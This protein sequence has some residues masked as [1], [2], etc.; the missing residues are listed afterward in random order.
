MSPRRRKWPWIAAL[1]VLLAAAYAAVGGRRPA[2][3]AVRVVRQDLV[4]TVV[5]TGRVMAPARVSVG[6]LVTGTVAV[7]AAREGSHVRAG[8]LLVALDPAEADA[9]ARQAR[10]A[11]AQASA[12]L[13]QLH[14]VSARLADQGVAQARADLDQAEANFTRAEGLRKYGIVTD[15]DLD[16]ARTARDRA[17]SQYESAVIQQAGASR[18]GVEERAA[19]AAIDQATATVAAAE[20]RLAQT[21]I[22]APAD[23]VLIE[24]RVEAGDLV[25]VGQVL[26]LLATDGP[27]RLTA[28]PDEKH[29]GSLAL[30]QPALA[31]AEA[32]PAG[33]FPATVSYLAPAVD[34][35]RG[36]IEVRLDVPQPP[37]YLRPDMTVSI[38]IEVARRHAVLVVPVEA[39]RGATSADPSVLVLEG[40][41]TAPR[42][43]AIGI[44]TETAVEITKGLAEG[45]MVVVGR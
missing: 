42:A 4:H 39:V 17:R 45:D 8:Q 5:A 2:P 7:L 40:T 31:S 38:E 34:A 16:Q 37:A 14:Q 27:T 25:V 18:A 44:R 33:R 35:Q 29:L 12:R 9:A 23:G 11:A 24:R 43:V 36:T 26:F 15:A 30:G 28:A 13:E 19:R 21:R 41:K 10:A 6:S 3:A 1:L 32:F 20:T 22:V